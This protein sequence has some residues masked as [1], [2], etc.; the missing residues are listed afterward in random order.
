MQQTGVSEPQISPNRG[1]N[2]KNKWCVY[3]VRPCEK[4]GYQMVNNRFMTHQQRNGR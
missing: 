3:V 2:N 1:A 4:E